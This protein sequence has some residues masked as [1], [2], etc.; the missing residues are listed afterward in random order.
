MSPPD[1]SR[2]P[3][4]RSRWERGSGLVDLSSRIYSRNV[5]KKDDDE[6]ERKKLRVVAFWR[7]DISTE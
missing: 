4:A 3:D 1:F 7:P 6:E 5:M 2:L